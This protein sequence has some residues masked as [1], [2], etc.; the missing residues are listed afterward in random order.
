MTPQLRIEELEKGIRDLILLLAS[1]GFHN[2]IE[3]AAGRKLLRNRDG[4]NGLTKCDECGAPAGYDC[5]TIQGPIYPPHSSRA[6]NPAME[7]A[8]LIGCVIE[9]AW[10]GS[11]SDGRRND[12]PPIA[13]SDDERRHLGRAVLKFYLDRLAA[14]HPNP[15][16]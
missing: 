9:D 8:R 16:L 1:T 13:L 7:K 4:Y 12:L 3:A 2:S 15:R 6:E 5:R 14:T 11:G 10:N